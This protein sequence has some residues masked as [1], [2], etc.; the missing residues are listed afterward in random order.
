LTTCLQTTEQKM[1]RISIVKITSL[2]YSP[3]KSS[4]NL[5]LE[6]GG[7]QWLI[8]FYP[9]K[10]E[11]LCKRKCLIIT[12]FFSIILSTLLDWLIWNPGWIVCFCQRILRDL[13]CESQ[14]VVFTEWR[15][16]KSRF[17]GESD[18]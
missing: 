7:P 13:L 17:Q 5:E 9:V 15:P 1:W 3:D 12:Y 6:D 4:Q 10:S 16:E 18:Q 2:Q 11:Y 8:D 14:R